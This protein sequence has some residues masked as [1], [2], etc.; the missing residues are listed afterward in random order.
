MT[1]DM[2]V[3]R[4]V[5]LGDHVLKICWSN[6]CHTQTTLR[7]VAGVGEILPTPVG[8]QTPGVSP[9]T[10]A[11]RSP[12]PTAG[13]TSRPTSTPTSTAT[14]RP[15][16][17]PT[18]QPTSPPTSTPTKTPC[19]TSALNPVFGKPTQ[20]QI[21]VGGTVVSVSGQNFVPSRTVTLHYTPG[22]G[23]QQT[24]SASVACDGSIST[25][26]RT[27]ALDVSGK[28]VASDGVKPAATVTF[29]V[30]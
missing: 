13:S 26:F 28:L 8:N 14:S 22:V 5:N 7:V 15:T 20:G 11:G 27:G 9:T 16:S 10:G 24:W 17:T 21:I 18:S 1:L 4:D 2:T 3:P 25:S 29:T 19:P 30:T 23:T 6:M 12:T